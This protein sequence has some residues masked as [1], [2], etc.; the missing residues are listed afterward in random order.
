MKKNF[1][2]V[3]VAF[4]LIAVIVACKDNKDVTGIRLAPDHLTLAVGSTAKFAYVVLPENARNKNVIWES[5]DTSVV[6]VLNG[7]FTAKKGGKVRITATTEEGHYKAYSVIE[8]IQIYLPEM[9]FVEG[10]TFT[11]GCS[12]DECTDYELP[13]HPASVFDYYISKNLITQKQWVAIMGYNP[14]YFKGDELPVENVNWYDVQNFITRL[15]ELTHKNYRLPTEAEW[16][17]AARGGNNSQGYTYSGSDNL[18]DV[19]WYY[20]NSNYQTHPV[21][22]KMANELEIYDMSGNVNEWC[23]DLFGYYTEDPLTHPIAPVTYYDRVI[24]GGSWCNDHPYDCR[25]SM[26]LWRYQYDC[27]NDIGFRLVLPSGYP[28]GK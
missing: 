28:I 19:A 22:E 16:E 4:L 24:R 27:R 11:M 1:K 13:A 18:D 20:G 17:F 15:N 14:S 5:S 12:D 25:V 21:G 26:R 3:T 2:I 9:V 6:S 10:G 7:V 8:V 23:N